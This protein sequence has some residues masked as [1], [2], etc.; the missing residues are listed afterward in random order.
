MEKRLRGQLAEQKFR[1]LKKEMQ[2]TF[3]RIKRS[4]QAEIMPDTKDVCEFVEQVAMMISYPGFGDG[5]YPQFLSASEALA[6]ASVAGDREGVNAALQA[7][8]ILQD[9]CHQGR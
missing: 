7:I 8:V 2:R 9:R 3:G 6:S 1:P 5:S 4:V